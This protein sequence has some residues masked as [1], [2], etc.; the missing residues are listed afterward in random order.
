MLHDN[1]CM[2]FSDVLSDKQPKP[3]TT[4]KVIWISA[5]V[6]FVVG[7]VPALGTAL[8]VAHDLDKEST[9][10]SY[11]NC[12]TLR[13][14]RRGLNER[15]RQNKLNL[16]ADLAVFETVLRFTPK[17]VTPGSRV[18]QAQ[19]DVYISSLKNAVQ[20]KKEK[21]LPLTKP[22]SL[23]DCERD[24]GPQTVNTPLGAAFHLVATKFE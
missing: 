13:E 5:L 22:S 24:F 11:D 20:T 2:P 21:I 4:W 16:E 7:C 3:L 8:V 9:A 18:T 6:A 1:Q 19:L 12:V 23:P 15:Q 10:R 17:K 14:G